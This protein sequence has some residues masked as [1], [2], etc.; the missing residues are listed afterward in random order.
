MGCL[1]AII[2]A[3]EAV[4][5]TIGKIGGEKEPWG[6]LLTISSGQP[7]GQ[8]C[9]RGCVRHTTPTP[10]L[11]SGTSGF[12]FFRHKKPVRQN[13]LPD[14][15]QTTCQTFFSQTLF[16]MDKDLCDIFQLM[17]LDVTPLT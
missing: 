11:V 3:V 7:P 9:D 1:S 8:S 14:K 5:P 16:Q 4:D 10:V 13:P 15:C 17:K 12:F 2:H 6:R